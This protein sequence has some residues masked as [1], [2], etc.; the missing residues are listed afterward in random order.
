[1]LFSALDHEDLDTAGRSASFATTSEGEIHELLQLKLRAA[2]LLLLPERGRGRRFLPLSLDSRGLEQFYALNVFATSR[3]ERPT[4]AL[5]MQIPGARSVVAAVKTR[6]A[7]SLMG[8]GVFASQRQK[9]HIN[10][11]RWSLLS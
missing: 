6:N 5:P 10:R 7:L 11:L 9:M 1:L 3:A 4:F 2:Y 8:C